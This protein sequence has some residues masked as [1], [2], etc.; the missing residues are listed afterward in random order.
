MEYF[1]TFEGQKIQPEIQRCHRSACNEK[2]RFQKEGKSGSKKD[3]M[4]GTREQEEQKRGGMEGRE[5]NAEGC[6]PT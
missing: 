2:G 6:S 3:G 4:V 1:T 5:P